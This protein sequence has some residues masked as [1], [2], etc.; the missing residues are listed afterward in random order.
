MIIRLY[1]GDVPQHI[2]VMHPAGR[3]SLGFFLM[4]AIEIDFG[5]W[6]IPHVCNIYVDTQAITQIFLFFFESFSFPIGPTGY[7]TRYAHHHTPCVQ[8]CN[9]S[10][11]GA[12]ELYQHGGL[13]V[14]DLS[15][16]I[17]FSTHSLQHSDCRKP[18]QPRPPR[19][20]IVRSCALVALLFTY[21]T[22]SVL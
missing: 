9:S 5:K 18:V 15:P 19:K 21:E 6:M 4:I 2:G 20:H 11:G 17:P 14:L 7:G 3:E 13:K 16:E 1:F 22:V 8:R 10:T 12:E